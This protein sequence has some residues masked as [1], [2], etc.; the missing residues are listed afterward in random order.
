MKTVARRHGV[1]FSGG[2]RLVVRAAPSGRRFAAW[3]QSVEAPAEYAHA[4][5]IPFLCAAVAPHRCAQLFAA[6]PLSLLSAPSPTAATTS[7]VVSR[8]TLMSCEALHTARRRQGRRS[9]KIWSGCVAPATRPGPIRATLRMPRGWIPRAAAIHPAVARAGEW[10][11]WRRPEP[12]L[13]CDCDLR[14]SFP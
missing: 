5:S 8:G 6:E 12:A 7:T 4:P 11:N 13:P 3:G 2:T 1:R 9:G 14:L 10:R